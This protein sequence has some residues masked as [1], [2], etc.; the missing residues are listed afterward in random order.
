MTG[1]AS[2]NPIPLPTSPLTGEESLSLP[3]KGRAGEGMGSDSAF[4]ETERA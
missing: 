3:F 1:L 4:K 2:A